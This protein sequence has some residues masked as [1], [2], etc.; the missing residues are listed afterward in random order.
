M[1]STAFWSS[2]ARRSASSLSL[3]S[4]SS[5]ACLHT[6]HPLTSDHTPTQ[7]TQWP[8]NT[9]L[10]TSD[11]TPTQHAHWL[12]EKNLAALGTQSHV[13]V[14]PGF[15][16]RHSTTELFPPYPHLCRYYSHKLLSLP[17]YPH[18]SVPHTVCICC[19]NWKLHM[20]FPNFSNI[21]GSFQLL[22]KKL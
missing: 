16:V 5:R 14:T 8:H 2:M 15:S 12:W 1:S 13:S 11:Y 4:W 7:H 21:Y 22:V 3:C 9:P 17:H 10:L 20:H 19:L 18:S 6:A